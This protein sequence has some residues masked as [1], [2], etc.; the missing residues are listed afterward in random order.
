MI[1]KKISDIVNNNVKIISK[2]IKYKKDFFGL[3][4]AP[5]IGRFGYPNV[6]VG[7][8]SSVGKVDG[9]ELDN[10]SK[11]MEDNK[12]VDEIVGIRSSLVNSW[13]IF[14]NISSPSSRSCGRLTSNCAAP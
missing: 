9:E 4:P 10:V 7:I 12:K 6:N 14:F 13:A 3:T 2:N 8:L 1:P 11:W 5:F